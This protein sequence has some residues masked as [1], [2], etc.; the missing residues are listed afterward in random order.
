M[1]LFELCFSPVGWV[2]IGSQCDTKMVLLPC[3]SLKF[4]AAMWNPFGKP[5]S[6]VAKA[7]SAVISFNSYVFCPSVPFFFPF[8]L[9]GLPVCILG[10]FSQALGWAEE[11]AQGQ[12]LPFG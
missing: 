9:S 4:K 11:D 12:G 10:R 7:G 5:K 3:V 8:Q 1:Y 6:F 2:F